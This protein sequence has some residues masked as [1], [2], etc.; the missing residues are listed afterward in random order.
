ML[1]TISDFQA[2]TGYFVRDTG[3]QQGELDAAD[4]VFRATDAGL[5]EVPFAEAV[6]AYEAAAQPCI[7]PQSREVT[8]QFAAI[9]GAFGFTGTGDHDYW[10]RR[11][12][13]L[14][15]T[16][17]EFLTNFALAVDPPTNAALAERR[18]V[19][20]DALREGAFSE[21]N[22]PPDWSGRCKKLAFTA[23]DIAYQM[24]IKAEA[25]PVNRHIAH[26][27]TITVEKPNAAAIAARIHTYIKIATAYAFGG[28][29][30]VAYWN[31]RTKMC[32]LEAMVMTS[33]VAAMIG[34][35]AR[36]QTR[37]ALVRLI[38]TAR[39]FAADG[40]GDFSYW[41]DRC[42]ELCASTT[43]LAHELQLT[44]G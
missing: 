32:A 3:T 31:I 20:V 28:R 8:R 44:I 37:D 41:S 35:A 29:G 12:K 9:A 25:A 33:D 36:P 1:P 24:D 10:S 21:S 26:P 7:S 5:T 14:A 13:Q 40:A 15:A 19:F 16:G 34:S 18:T 6:H 2:K 23:T 4:K 11:T 42:K 43:A 22:D 17:A 39:T 30:D 38:S 27:S